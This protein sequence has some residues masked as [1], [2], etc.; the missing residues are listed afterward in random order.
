MRELSK[1]LTDLREI[2]IHVVTRHGLM[3][4]GNIVEDRFSLIA[5]E[6][7]AADARPSE[8]VRRTYNALIVVIALEG[9]RAGDRD[10]LSHFLMVAGQMLEPLRAD[11]WRAL[12]DEKGARDEPTRR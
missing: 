2:A 10:G 1:T 7:R 6:V 4:G 11:A 3:I 5:E 9:Y 8:G 12:N